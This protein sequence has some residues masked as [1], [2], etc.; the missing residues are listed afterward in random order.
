VAA[1]IPKVPRGSPAGKN[2][3]LPGGAS[4]IRKGREACRGGNDF[5]ARKRGTAP[6]TM[7]NDRGANQCGE[8]ENVLSLHLH[9]GTASVG[10]SLPRESRKQCNEKKRDFHSHKEAAIFRGEDIKGREKNAAT[11]QPGPP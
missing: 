9:L 7:G 3:G 5:G 8:V 4:P 10:G 11:C 2:S 1:G 6:S